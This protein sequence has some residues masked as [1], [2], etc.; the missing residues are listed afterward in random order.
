MTSISKEIPQSLGEQILSK[1]NDLSRRVSTIER[2]AKKQD[3]EEVWLTEEYVIEKTG[4]SK[5][6]LQV[7]RRSGKIAA[8]DWKSSNGRKL[9]YRKDSIE[10]LFKS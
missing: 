5:K 9:Q 8:S 4:Y 6:S 10:E 1:L 3:K 7:M 2:I